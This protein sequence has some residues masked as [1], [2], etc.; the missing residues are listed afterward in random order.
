MK[1]TET[2]QKKCGCHCCEEELKDGCLEPPFCSPCDVVFIK[3]KKCGAKLSKTV[4]KC[5]ACG[6]EQ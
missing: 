2:G 5:S 4:K 1:N 6:Q 3:C